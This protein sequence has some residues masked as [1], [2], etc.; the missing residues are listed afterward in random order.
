MLSYPYIPNQIIFNNAAGTFCICSG[1]DQTPPIFPATS[2]SMASTGDYGR[3]SSEKQNPFWVSMQQ[4]AYHRI[5]FL[6]PLYLGDTLKYKAIFFILIP[7]K[8]TFFCTYSCLRPV[9]LF[10]LEIYFFFTEVYSQLLNPHIKKLIS[11][12]LYEIGLKI[13]KSIIFFQKDISQ[14]Q[15]HRDFHNPMNT[16]LTPTAFTA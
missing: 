11:L 9:N 1:R 7:Y 12:F 6:I 3:I 8:E 16:N 10:T 15:K 14:A 4:I 13:V 5:F 2:Q